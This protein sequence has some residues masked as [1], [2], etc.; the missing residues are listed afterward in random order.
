MAAAE[1]IGTELALCR[2]VRPIETIH[3]VTL[4]EVTRQFDDLTA[5]DDVTFDVPDGTILGII[6]P[7]GSGKTT[8]VRMMVGILERTEGEI[9]VLGQD[10]RRFRRQTREQIG[11]MPQ[12]FVLYPDLTAR[13]NLSFVASLF[14]LL[15]WRKQRRVREVLEFV[16][17]W[18]A[19][20][21]RARDL[22]GGMQR[23]L[24]LACTLVHEPTLLF[25]DEPTAGLDPVL[26]QT[27]WNEFRRLRDEGRTLVV[28]TQYVG[29]AEHCDR[30]AVLEH[31]RLVA[32]KEPEQLRRDAMGGEIIEIVTRD[33]VDGP[34][35]LADIPGVKRV[36]Q[37]GPRRLEITAEE[38]GAATPRILKVLSDSGIQVAS[39]AERRPSFDEVFGEL[40]AQRGGERAARGA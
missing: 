18:D 2:R 16:G 1:Q 35:L 17:L 39:S 15:W 40:M 20:D 34:A 5:V 25:V 3:P 30:V 8:L 32:L 23:R 9:R 24:E 27:I 36:R 31:G 10:P 38:A 22:S 28:T 6:G 19:R 7:S 37:S 11:Y 4:R 26:R 14:G 21:R 12:L 29:E 13:E 33:L